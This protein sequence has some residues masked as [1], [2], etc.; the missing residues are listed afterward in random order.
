VSE[1]PGYS[2]EPKE[3]I[4]V[5]VRTIGGPSVG[6]PAPDATSV[7]ENKI[8]IV[9]LP[10]KKKHRFEAAKVK[11]GDG[12]IIFTGTEGDLTGKFCLREVKGYSV[13]VDRSEEPHVQIN[14]EDK[15]Q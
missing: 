13:E 5:V 1:V 14:V 10:S 4:T 6:A 8:W 9:L 11:G 7:A 12:S 2:V 15:G 3:V